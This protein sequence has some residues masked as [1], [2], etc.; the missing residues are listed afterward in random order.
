MFVFHLLLLLF[1]LGFLLFHLH[2]HL[3]LLLFHF[4]LLLFS[5]LRGGIWVLLLPCCPIS[6]SASSTSRP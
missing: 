5:L 2:I 1:H 4:H 6:S 3:H